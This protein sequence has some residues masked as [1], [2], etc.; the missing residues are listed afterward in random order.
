MNIILNGTDET[1][2]N[3]IVAI[4]A[5]QIALVDLLTLIGIRPF[6]IIGHFLCELNCSYADGAFTLEQT[7]L[8]AY[9]K[10]KSVLDSDLEP[11]AMAVVSLNWDETKK[12]CSPDIT[13]A[14]HNSVNL[15][16]IS[17]PSESMKKFVEEL[18]SKDIFAKII[19]SSGV[20][21]HNKYIAPTE[22]KYR[23]F[24]DMIITKP[25]Q[26]SARWISSSVPEAAWGSPLTQFSSSEY[27]VNNMLSPVLF[28]EAIAHI[29]ENAITIEI[30]PHCLLQSILRSSLPSTVTNI[31]LQKQNYS[32]NL[33]FLLSNVGKLY[34]A[35]AQPNISKLYQFSR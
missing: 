20:A 28:Q 1:Y 15:V 5:I 11:G 10:G 18:K 29:P 19:N 33:I 24:L 17:G 32:N 23:A 34:M 31:S 14:C 22:S 9:Y 8:A 35:G 26:K 25:K 4:V 30:A 7:I 3:V 21:F 2:N 27:H 16:T 6:G 13:P 12:M